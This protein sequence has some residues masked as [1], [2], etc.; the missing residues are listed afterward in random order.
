L[1]RRPKPFRTNPLRRANGLALATW[2]VCLLSLAGWRTL[3]AE[4][5]RAGCARLDITP[6][7]P[8]T[9]A[10][11]ASR[12]DL[13]RGVHDP[14]SARVVALEQSGQRLVLVSVD[15]LGFYNGTAAPLRK[16]ILE[17]CGLKPAELFLCAIHTHSAPALT[18]DSEKG[19][20]NNVQYTQTLQGKLVEAVRNALDRLAP[21]Q[22][23]VGAG[24][25]PVGANR[26]EVVQG[27]DGKTKIVL[28]RNP[29]VHTDREVQVLKL[30]RP[31]Q[32]QLAGA[33]FAY[34]THSTSLGPGNYLVSG[35]VHGLAEQFLENYLGADV[36]APGF[37]G[38]SGDIDPWFRIKPD[39][40][41]NN[42]WLPEPVLLGTFLGEEVAHVLEGIQG[43]ATNTAIKTNFKAVELPAKPRGE[44]Q[45]AASLT[46]P[47][48]LTVGRVGEIAFVGLGGE[49]FNEIGKAIKSASPFPRT[50]IFTHCN[51]AAGYLPTR[52]S[53]PQGGY[54]VQS[55]SFA[56]GAD[57][58]L[59]QETT[60]LLRELQ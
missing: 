38:A 26:R 15:N 21:A 55:S 13:S 6:A 36:V 9:L 18:L 33:L 23:G 12:K 46:L 5:L 10:G 60:R 31:G 58:L 11:Y 29:S 43:F 34:A 41:T 20:T 54:E 44:A 37:A 40:K 39:F 27:T 16:A 24:S 1:R 45:P 4:E 56:P 52:P 59:L 35:D 7:Q 17:A 22:V 14:L 51:G 50:F 2:C 48:N 47:F 49:V 25:C 53:Y 3:L 19:H 32:N 42:A 8:V 28:G 30:A 57:E